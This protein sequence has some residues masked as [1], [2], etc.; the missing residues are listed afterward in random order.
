MLEAGAVEGAADDDVEGGDDAEWNEEEED[1]AQ[2]DDQLHV[3]VPV[4]GDVAD[5][6]LGYEVISVGVYAGVVG[7]GEEGVGQGT[8]TRAHPHHDYNPHCPG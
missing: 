2:P 3:S 6:R 7:T 1:E 5:E 8:E 4:V